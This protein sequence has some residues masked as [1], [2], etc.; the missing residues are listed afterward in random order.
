MR[1]YLARHG[2]TDWNI[3]ERFQGWADRPLS[4]IGK[5]QAAE[6]R[7]FLRSVRFAA[8]YSSD[9]QRARR[10]AEIVLD[11]RGLEVRQ[12]KGLREMN[13][14]DLDGLTVK[15]IT[16]RH[17]G[18]LETWRRDPGR[19]TMPG[20]ESL[21]MVRERAAAAVEGVAREHREGNVLVVAHHT[22]NKTI[23]CS[24]LGI[25]FSGI[26]VLR[27]PPCALSVIDYLDDRAFLRAVNVNWRGLPSFAL[28]VSPEVKER[29]RSC[30][31]LVFDM[32]GV[33]LD[34]MPFYAAAWS[35][36]LAEHGVAA[37]LAEFYRRES[38]DP[39]IEVPQLFAL[40][41]TSADADKARSV[42]ARALEL[43][44]GFPGIKPFPG[45]AE[46]LRKLRGAGKATALVTGSHAATVAR[47]LGDLRPLFDAIVALEDAPHRKPEPHPF[48]K[49]LDMLGVRPE[50]AVA[51]ENSPFGIRS[52][53]AA[54]I[55]TVGIS[56]TLPPEELAEADLVIDA[57]ERLPGRLG[58]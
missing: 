57:L 43:Y 54:G 53:K 35:C 45:A 15:D 37:P 21:E 8:A 27:Q 24:L 38:G 26:H 3:E 31:A 47:L 22:T 17:P 32:D 1:L 12:I 51:V 44:S 49:A 40:A 5:R 13:M 28:D 16:A 4:E 23:L 29:L 56:T 9:L 55:L 11:G 36:A 25:P 18:A 30:E 2:E 20:G 42:A 50:Q 19:C 7:E 48:L 14:G 41:G 33:I 46:V 52:A 6:L 10:T 39:D 58:L 34:S